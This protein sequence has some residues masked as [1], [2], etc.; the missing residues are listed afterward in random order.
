MSRKVKDTD[1]VSNPLANPFTWVDVISFSKVD[2]ISKSEDQ[3]QAEKSYNPFI[4][5]RHFSYFPDTVLYANEINQYPNL[6]KKMQYDYYMKAI[7]PRK[8]F[9]KW[10][11]KLED[12]T[13]ELVSEFYQ[14][15][16]KKTQEA[17]RLLT[18]DQIKIIQEKMDKGGEKNGK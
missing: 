16:S 17:M 18:P 4:I 8:R 15:N 13:F 6:D 9:T 2:L 5:N 10:V 1:A 7:R 11:K 12:E 14:L 3:E